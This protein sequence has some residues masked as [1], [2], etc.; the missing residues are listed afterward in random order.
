MGRCNSHTHAQRN[1]SQNLFFFK[2]LLSESR[3]IKR[4]KHIN[5][6]G[7]RF[8]QNASH[9]FLV[10]SKRCGHLTTRWFRGRRCFLRP[11]KGLQGE[12]QARTFRAKHLGTCFSQ[13]SVAAP[14]EHQ[15]RRAEHD[16][17]LVPKVDVLCIWRRLSAHSG[18][19]EWISELL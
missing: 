13:T 5:S 6:Y 8:K 15:I 11:P 12:K 16:A 18:G 14:P 9:A 17:V 1:F 4:S 19:K 2:S 7:W 10:P 3:M